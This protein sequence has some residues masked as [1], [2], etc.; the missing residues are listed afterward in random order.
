[1][2]VLMIALC[3]Y[4]KYGCQNLNE[5]CVLTSA[6]VRNISE[7]FSKFL[8]YVRGVNEAGGRVTSNRMFWA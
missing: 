5:E 4:G 3:L 8:V 7:D 2:G 1:M 6:V